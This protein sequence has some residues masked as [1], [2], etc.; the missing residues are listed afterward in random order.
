MVKRNLNDKLKVSKAEIHCTRESVNLVT[1]T[2][3]TAFMCSISR[4]L[5]N[6]FNARVSDNELERRF[7]KF[8]EITQ[9]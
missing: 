1:Y 6:K 2:N 5:I 9:K 4:L 7:T 3:V 8:V